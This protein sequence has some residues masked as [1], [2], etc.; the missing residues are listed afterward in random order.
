MALRAKNCIIAVDAMGGDYA[1]QA[2]IEGALAAAAE[3]IP[4]VLFGDEKVIEQLLFGCDQEWKKLPLE[5]VHCT[6]VIAMDEEPSKAVL[7]KK[8]ASLIKA[9]HSVV[10]GR[11]HAVVSAGNSGAVLVA[12]TVILGR[13]AGVLRPAIGGFL[14]TQK[15]SVFCIDLGANTDCKTEYLE[16]FAFM[17]H[18]YVSVVHGMTSPRIGL[19]SNGHEPYKGSGI[20]KEAYG[21]LTQ[22]SLN[23]V[24]NI[25]ARDI[26][27]DKTDVL[28]CD[29][30]SGNIMLKTA[31][32]T[33]RVMMDWLKQEAATSWWSKAALGLSAPLLKKLKS[34]TDYSRIGGALLL[35]VQHP[36]ITAHGS[37]NAQAIA[38][39]ISFAHAVVQ[40]QIIRRFNEKLVEL[41][42]KQKT[43]FSTMLERK[44]RSLLSWA[45]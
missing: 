43:S 25:E 30:F 34:K 39:A 41:L 37:S 40:K 32:A 16:Q 26:F 13:T 1:P 45:Q 3:G 42:H 9:M 5:I 11:T 19:L 17:G 18:A 31:Q 28:V 35:G 24:G 38:H 23:F 36:V 14:P 29:G 10:N 27:N 15:G 2:V 21:R 22:S 44:E 7:R 12:S 20:V 33:A 4:V 6:D 8:D